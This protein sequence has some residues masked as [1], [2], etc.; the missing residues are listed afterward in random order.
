MRKTSWKS[1]FA[2]LALAALV[3][4]AFAKPVSMVINIA[5]NQKVAG[6]ELKSDAYTFKVDDTKLTVELKHKVVVE[7]AGR[8]E[9]RDQKIEAN[10]IV[11]G[12]DGQVQELRFSGEKRVFVIDSK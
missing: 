2:V 3:M 10:S 8:W 4:P 11:F 12:S 9:P 1:I 7:A 5:N 6:K